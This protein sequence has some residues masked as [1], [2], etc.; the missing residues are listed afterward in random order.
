[1]KSSVQTHLPD[2][3]IARAQAYIE[4]GGAADLDGLLTEA[5]RRFLD[6]HAADLN[7]AFLREDVQWGLHGTD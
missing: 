4:D 1:M 3:L 2:E 7:D 5:L 6:S